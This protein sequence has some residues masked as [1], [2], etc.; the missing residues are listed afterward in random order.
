MEDGERLDDLRIGG[1]KIFQNERQFCFSLDAVLLAHFATLRKEARIMD[2]GTG[3]GV[4]PL[5]LTARGAQN[6][7]ALEL[8]EQMVHLARKSI[9]YNALEEKISVCSG[10]LR[11]INALFS[12]ETFDLVI[13][14]P[15]YRPLNNGKVSALDGIAAARHEITA[16]LLDV[17]RAAAYLLRTKAR[18]A[19]VHLPERLAE[20]VHA[21]QSLHIEPKR[22]RFVQSTVGQKPKMVLIEGVKGAAPGLEVEAP[23]IIYR[24]LP[25]GRYSEE[26]LHYYEI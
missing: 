16:N 2:L 13:S 10:D 9:V 3:T 25:G 12:A 24:N 20:I 11:E 18:F 1:L 21:M 7:M 6:I 19:M 26:M 14:N 17:V 22:L 15:P 4:I 8:N 5:I 23:L